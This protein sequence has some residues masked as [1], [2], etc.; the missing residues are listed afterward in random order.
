MW[1][2]EPGSSRLNGSPGQ[3]TWSLANHVRPLNLVLCAGRAWDQG[4]TI[5]K[6]AF[7]QGDSASVA[8]GFGGERPEAGGP[9]WKM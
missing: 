7:W 2:G 5:L 9:I 4:S 3:L 6:L 1:E 8:D